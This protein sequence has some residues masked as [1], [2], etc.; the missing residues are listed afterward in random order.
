MMMHDSSSKFKDIF[1]STSPRRTKE[2]I[3]MMMMMIL[4][5]QIESQ[6]QK[7]PVY[8]DDD[9]LAHTNRIPTT[10]ATGIYRL[11]SLQR[12]DDEPLKKNA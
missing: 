6:Q 7:L 11:Y 4:P 1:L 3:M 5:T 10:K 2:V 9:D 12:Y 8:I